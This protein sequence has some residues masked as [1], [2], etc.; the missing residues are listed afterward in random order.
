MTDVLE[1]PWIWSTSKVDAQNNVVSFGP[2]LTLM[3]IIL[4]AATSFKG[5]KNNDANDVSN[6]YCRRT[7]TAHQKSI[8]LMGRGGGQVVSMVAFNSDDASS[9]PAE[10]SFYSV[11]SF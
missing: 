11:N 7:S 10:Y 9:N 1:P 2:I 6:F 3:S 8:D 5:N 4:S